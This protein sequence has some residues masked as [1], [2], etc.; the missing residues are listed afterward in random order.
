M[1]SG[2]DAGVERVVEV[3][4]EGRLVVFPLD[5]DAR[6][7]RLET[8]DRVLDVFVEE[9]RQVNVQK[10]ISAS[11]STP[12]MTASARSGA[13][14]V[15]LA[16][17]ADALGLTEAV[18]EADAGGAA[19]VAIGDGDTTGGGEQAV[20][21]SAKSAVSAMYRCCCNVGQRTVTLKVWTELLP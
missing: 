21:T 4:L 1:T 9:G 7:G 14:A 15:G 11:G 13:R 3:G 5:R 8:G 2:R 19:G 16:A 17:A 10:P 18:A 6:I 12:L 20:T